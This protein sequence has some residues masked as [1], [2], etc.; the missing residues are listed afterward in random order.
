MSRRHW[1]GLLLLAFAVSTIAVWWTDA[2]SDEPSPGVRD[3]IDAV[4]SNASMPHEEAPSV[5]D[6][7]GTGW[8][9]DAVAAGSHFPIPADAPWVPVRVLDGQTG[10]PVEGAEVVWLFTQAGVVPWEMLR[11]LPPDE[12]ERLSLDREAAAREHGSSARSDANGLVEVAVRPNGVR[13]YARAVGRYGTAFVDLV[14][15]PPPGG[16]RLLLLPERELRVAVLDAE[17]KPAIGVPVRIVR[18]GDP[19]PKYGSPIRY[20]CARI[21]APDGVA[22]LM[23]LQDRFSTQQRQSTKGWRVRVELPYLNGV[24]APFDPE[25][26]PAEPVELHLPP[27]GQMLAR[28]TFEGRRPDHI[29]AVYLYP[30]EPEMVRTYQHAARRTSELDGWVC[31]RHVPLGHHFVVR[32]SQTGTTDQRVAGP[33]VADETVRIEITR[34]PRDPMITGRLVDESG[35]PMRDVEGYTR[36]AWQF[37]LGGGRGS[38]GSELRSDS[39]G[40][41]RY[42]C[43]RARGNEVEY[44]RLDFFVHRPNAALLHARI[45]PRTFAMGTTDLGDLVM[46][47]APVLVAGRLQFPPGVRPF[48][49]G[50]E[51]EHEVPSDWNPAELVWRGVQDDDVQQDDEGRFVVTGD[52]LPGRWRLILVARGMRNGM[53]FPFEA[54]QRDLVVPLV[55]GAE[56]WATLRMP[57]SLQQNLRG[58]LRPAVQPAASNVADSRR[59]A[60]PQAH[61]G[62][63]H[64]LQWQGL[65]PGRYTIELHLLGF[66]RPLLSIP[67]VVVPSPPGGNPRL[68]DLDVQSLVREV[69]VR[70]LGPEPNQLAELRA[71]PRPQYRGEQG[72]F[73]GY[74]AVDGLVLFPTPA[75]PIDLLLLCKGFQSVSLRGVQGEATV[76]LQPW[77]EVQVSLPDMPSLPAGVRL[78]ARLQPGP[79]GPGDEDLQPQEVRSVV[80]GRVALPFG[81]GN[82][83]L[84]LTLVRGSQERSFSL[85]LPTPVPTRDGLVELRDARAG[86]ERELEALQQ[87]IRR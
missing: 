10:A 17:G 60:F 52:P 5:A 69:S 84:S 23:H 16:H 64:A 27:T 47:P 54:G 49:V 55:L 75:K 4:P 36:E 18:D 24:S 32:A 38:G 8:K 21:A 41:F 61:D 34:P 29:D 7:D 43:A 14:G 59:T 31:F 33:T 83:V 87:T 50:F 78:L 19:E 74:C 1:M 63:R 44:H 81:P 86:I 15:T 48:Q 28:T 72:F 67:D 12:E 82:Q 42:G 71:W 62:I 30:D 76:T 22:R 13:L 53:N 46:A 45:G 2:A 66:P 70:V 35:S 68:L 57:A 58:I 26:L 20:E 25:A 51:L 39:D 11:R 9:R 65:E 80:D 37:S 40:R 85:S 73:E 6:A 56:L 3:A 77:P 79:D